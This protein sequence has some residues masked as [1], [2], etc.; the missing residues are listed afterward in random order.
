MKVRQLN[1]MGRDWLEE[2]AEY[3]QGKPIPPSR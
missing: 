3:G 1:V 2:E